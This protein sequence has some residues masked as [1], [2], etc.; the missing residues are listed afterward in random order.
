MFR[1]TLA[2]LAGLAVIL[3]TS[4]G[5]QAVVNP[6]LTPK[7]ALPNGEALSGNHYVWIL[8]SFY[9]FLCVIA[10]GYVT[11][12]LAPRDPNQHA[13]AL[14][15]IQ[16]ALTIPAVIFPGKAPIWVWILSMIAVIPVAWCGGL[17]YSRRLK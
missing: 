14:G 1:S 4:F 16:S 11:A 12:R 9:T 7:L 2:I 10:G 15:I 8:T 5:M 6:F 13:V 3:I 17:I